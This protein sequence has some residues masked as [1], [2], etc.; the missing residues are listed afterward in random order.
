[1]TRKPEKLCPLTSWLAMTLYSSCNHENLN[2]SLGIVMCFSLDLSQVDPRICSR[3]KSDSVL[4]ASDG[5][6]LNNKAKIKC[7]DHVLASCLHYTL[8]ILSNIDTKEN[9]GQTGSCLVH[10]MHC[11]ECLHFYLP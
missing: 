11:F 2:V 10:P 9:T 8:L 6:F 3:L 4:A 7:V 5:Q 1:M